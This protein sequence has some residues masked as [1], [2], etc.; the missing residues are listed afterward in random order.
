VEHEESQAVFEE[1]VV[2]LESYLNLKRTRISLEETWQKTKLVEIDLSL[3]E[4]FEHVFEWAA[5]PD[6]WTG[7]IKEFV[8][9]YKTKSGRAAVLNPQLQ[10]KRDYNPTVT[11]EKQA[12]GVE[13]LKVFGSWWEKNIMSASKDGCTDTIL[14]VPWSKGEPDYR[15]TY[16]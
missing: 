3:A 16:R 1:F 4:Y 6:Q 7:F 5:N 10:F 13:L 8:K 9:D 2:K 15:D 11:K 12:K 14:V